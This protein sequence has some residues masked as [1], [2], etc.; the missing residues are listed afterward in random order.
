M[1]FVLF[2][3][4]RF[5]LLQILGITILL[6]NFCV[7]NVKYDLEELIILKG[8]TLN[9]FFFLLTIFLKRKKTI[10]F[11]TLTQHSS[12]LFLEYPREGLRR[13]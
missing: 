12:R 13:C 2:P 5:L 3:S 11:F 4:C 7:L 8:L 10:F 9:F 6:L 1:S